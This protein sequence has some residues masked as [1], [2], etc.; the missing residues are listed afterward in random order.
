MKDRLTHVL[1]T[2]VMAVVQPLLEH[3]KR[4]RARLVMAM[5]HQAPSQSVNTLA[6]IVET[7]HLA[8]LVHDDIIDATPIRRG[9]HTT[10]AQFGV[11]QAVLSGD[12]LFALAMQWAYDL[13]PEFSPFFHTMACRM[14]NAE[15]QQLHQKAP[16]FHDYW[17]IIADKTGLLFS[18]AARLVS[19]L[20]GDNPL[21]QLRSAQ[22][23]LQVGILYQLLDD[24]LD[25]HLPNKQQDSAQG[26]FTYPCFVLLD[27]H[28]A[29]LEKLQCALKESDT[30]TVMHLLH[31]Y[32]I[33]QRSAESLRHMMMQQ[34]QALC[35]FPNVTQHSALHA[36][37][38]DVF[39]KR[40]Q[41]IP[42]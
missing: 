5:A 18:V 39:E 23:G 30:Q 31:Q 41:A 16:T 17:T 42:H 33:W 40:L 2:D 10:H 26:R 21:L 7:M 13:N 1:Q 11:S 36:W 12:Y 35:W 19:M 3:G 6:N 8:T 34:Q 15:L 37:L 29:A 14:V 22:W 9:Q 38:N 24:C 27:H 4:V 28:P 32:N 20:N 25:Y